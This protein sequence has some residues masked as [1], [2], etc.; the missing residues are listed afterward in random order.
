VSESNTDNRNGSVIDSEGD[1]KLSTN[2]V[3]SFFDLTMVTTLKEVIIFLFIMDLGYCLCT[4][5]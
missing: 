4:K 3:F 2:D 1:I 5:L